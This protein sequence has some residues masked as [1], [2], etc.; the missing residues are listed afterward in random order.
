MNNVKKTINNL[1]WICGSYIKFL[2][3]GLCMANTSATKLSRYQILNYFTE[4]PQKIM[5]TVKP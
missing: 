4:Q 2:K 1:Q 3:C 5:D